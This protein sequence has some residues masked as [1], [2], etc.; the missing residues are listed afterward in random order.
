MTLPEMIR[1]GSFL[2]DK[3]HRMCF[4]EF[5]PVAQD[6]RGTILEHLGNHQRAEDGFEPH[7]SLRAA[8][9]QQNLLSFQ[10]DEIGAV[11]TEALEN[12]YSM[13]CLTSKKVNREIS[14]KHSYHG[15]FIRTSK[16]VNRR[17]PQKS[18]HSRTVL[19]SWAGQWRGQNIY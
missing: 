13:N 3:F 7:P 1:C 12:Q 17:G 16:K 11:A 19:G 18:I 5:W 14:R 6:R 15:Q 9:A 8:F 10:C 4:N 2:I